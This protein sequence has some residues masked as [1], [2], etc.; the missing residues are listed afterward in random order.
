MPEGA[1]SFPHRDKFKQENQL[2]IACHPL[3]LGAFGSV[4][5][6][7]LPVQIAED[8]EVENTT[9]NRESLTFYQ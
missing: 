8:P 1:I 9:Y 4:D 3:L 5:G 6:L 7:M 2:I